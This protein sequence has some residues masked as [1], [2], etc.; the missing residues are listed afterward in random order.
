MA[1]LETFISEERITDSIGYDCQIN[2]RNFF[3]YYRKY[4]AGIESSEILIP[5]NFI[6]RN[7]SELL[8]A[9]AQKNTKNVIATH[10]SSR[11]VLLSA[12]DKDND[13]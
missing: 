10:G 11:N 12:S 6:I 8:R 7:E 3:S 9:Y 13:M 5:P 1:S 4:S 2:L